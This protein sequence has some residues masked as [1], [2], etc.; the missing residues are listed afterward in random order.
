MYDSVK[1]ASKNKAK[2]HPK[3]IQ[4]FQSKSPLVTHLGLQH[5]KFKLILWSLKF[6]Q[7]LMYHQ[8]EVR[9]VNA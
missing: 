1:R 7:K 2:S 6:F 9:E 4:K 8:S 5:L 3:L